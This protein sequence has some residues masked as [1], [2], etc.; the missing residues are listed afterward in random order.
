MTLSL[1]KAYLQH[2]FPFLFKY[3]VDEDG[4][5][6][7]LAGAKVLDEAGEELGALLGS[8][9]RQEDLLTR[10]LAEQPAQHRPLLLL[11]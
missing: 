3:H 11:P 10:G 2:L 4:L 5:K 8:A 7:V 9:L 6:V 1:S